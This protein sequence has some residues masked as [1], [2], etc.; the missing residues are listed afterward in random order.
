MSQAGTADLFDADAQGKSF[1]TLRKLALNL[2]SR[3]FSQG[4]RH[5]SASNVTTE[6][7]RIVEDP[8]EIACSIMRHPRPLL[9]FVS[10]PSYCQHGF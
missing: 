7:T 3:I 8:S 10:K 1:A 6:G 2:L 4:N 5:K 9:S